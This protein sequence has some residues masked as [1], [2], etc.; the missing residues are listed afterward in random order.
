M[1]LFYAT[2]PVSEAEAMRSIPTFLECCRQCPSFGAT[3]ACPPI[4][5][6]PRAV[7]APWKF[8][9]IY[10]C[11]VEPPTEETLFEAAAQLRDR[12]LEEEKRVGGLAV[13]GLG[14]CS[15]CPE[16]TRPLD[17]PCRHPD[18]VRLSLEALGYDVAALA[19]HA[20]L[21][22]EWGTPKRYLSVVMGLLHN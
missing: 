16:C 12:L 19:D 15:I 8:L 5:Q 1:K 14:P 7:T 18:R 6:D 3:W 22:I 17:L 11:A 2:I 4:P 10:A 20:G 9:T 21:K 13:S